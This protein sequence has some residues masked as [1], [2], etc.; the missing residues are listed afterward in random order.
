MGILFDS[1]PPVLQIQLRRFE[2]DFMKDIMI[3]VSQP[4]TTPTPPP[5]SSYVC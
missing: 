1:F 4:V 3:K 2:Y 5:L